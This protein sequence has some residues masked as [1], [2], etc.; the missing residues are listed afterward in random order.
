M[1]WAEPYWLLLLLLTPLPWLAERLRGHASWPTLTSFRRRSKWRPSPWKTWL[2][3]LVRTALVACL[4]LAM[5]RPQTVAGHTR[6]SARAVAI[7][8]VL[9]RSSSMKTADDESDEESP[10]RLEVARRT[11][12]RFIAGRPDDLFGLVGFANYPDLICPPTL[13]HATVRSAVSSLGPVRAGDDGTNIGDAL[14]RALEAVGPAP[15]ERKVIVLLTDGA[16]EPAVPEPLHPVEA[17]R[18]SRDL[19]VTLHTIAVGRAGGLVRGVEPTTGLSVP[20]NADG[21]DVD[22][23]SRMAALGGGLAF[24]AETP[25]DLDRIFQEIDRLEK[26]P[27]TGTVFTRYHEHYGPFVAGSLALLVL[28][29]LLGLGRW[30]RLP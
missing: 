19:G 5:A 8:V 7:M 9:D 23:L 6:V 15:T 20:A 3:P 18:L 16:N 22:L 1:R 4:S 17:A 11:I 24:H 28:D 27:V 26:S 14:A 2:T 10:S 29:G 12:D 21:P 30:R 13:D 25:S